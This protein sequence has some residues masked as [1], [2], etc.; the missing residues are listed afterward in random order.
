MRYEAIAKLG[1]PAYARVAVPSADSYSERIMSNEH[2][3][4]RRML[5]REFRRER[6]HEDFKATYETARAATQAAI[7]INGGAATAILAFLS[8]GTQT[9]PDVMRAACV[10]L[11]LY[12][13]G[14]ACGTLSMWYSSQAAGWFASAELGS[15]TDDR[16]APSDLKKA[17]VLLERHR[18]FFPASIVLFIVATFWFALKLS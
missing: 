5:P 18:I 3:E 10:S 6:V 13:L 9:P 17:R 11:G 7:L 15:L 4:S 8:K 16:D 1:I 2:G 14:V 12:A